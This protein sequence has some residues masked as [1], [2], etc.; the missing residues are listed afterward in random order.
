MA[1]EEQ[2]ATAVG[3][4]VHDSKEQNGAK[5]PYTAGVRQ[6]AVTGSRSNADWWP[7]QL[8]LRF[9][10]ST[11]PRPIPWTQRSITPRL[12]RS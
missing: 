3:E 7:N 12:S 10:I 9:C 1:K 11:I 5:C 2:F 4:P 6:Q 8:N